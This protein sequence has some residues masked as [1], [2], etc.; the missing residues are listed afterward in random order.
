M[1][2]SRMNPNMSEET[3]LNGAFYYNRTPLSL[4]GTKE[5]IHDKPG[6]RGNWDLQGTNGWYIGGKPEHYRCWT[7]YVI[8][9]A[10]EREI[11]TDNST[12][13]GISNDTIKQRRSKAMYTRFYCC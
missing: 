12:V 5:I 4:P 2:N 11:A 6:A 3:K 9:T 13:V 1:I 7:I 10:S 8:K